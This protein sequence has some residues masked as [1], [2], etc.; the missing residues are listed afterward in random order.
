[1]REIEKIPPAKASSPAAGKFPGLG[2][3]AACWKLGATSPRITKACKKVDMMRSQKPTP[4][5][6]RLKDFH[7]SYRSSKMKSSTNYDAIPA[8]QISLSSTG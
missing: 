3:K 5:S 8:R 6:L 7:H 4:L 1:M 2:T